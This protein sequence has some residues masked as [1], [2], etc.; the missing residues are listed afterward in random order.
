MVWLITTSDSFHFSI[1]QLTLALDRTITWLRWLL[2]L[3]TLFRAGLIYHVTLNLS[4]RWQ[5]SSWIGIS[6]LLLT[7]LSVKKLWRW[8][9]RSHDSKLLYPSLTVVLTP[10]TIAWINIWRTVFSS[11]FPWQSVA[12]L[13]ITN[14]LIKQVLWLN[15]LLKPPS[16]SDADRTI[17]WIHWFLS[18]PTIVSVD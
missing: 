7:F 10:L 13:S 18:P 11:Q 16:D 9:D 14:A 12:L 1:R 8:L 3:P 15:S 2:N 17:T 6:L 5:L 4:I